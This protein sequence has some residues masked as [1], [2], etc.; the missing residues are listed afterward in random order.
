MSYTTYLYP[1]NNNPNICCSFQPILD[2]TPM[3]KTLLTKVTSLGESNINWFDG[4]KPIDKL[5]INHFLK[6]LVGKK[7][8]VQ[9][10]TS[11][12]QLHPPKKYYCNALN[13]W[14]FQPNHQRIQLHTP[15]PKTNSKNP[16]ESELDPMKCSMYFWGVKPMFRCYV[17]GRRVKSP[18]G[19]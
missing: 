19:A 5:C 8:H 13:R 6:L 14:F 9:Q 2:L 12:K 4:F 11:F 1:K 18:L 7:K 17:L 10:T 15:S 3:E 16:W